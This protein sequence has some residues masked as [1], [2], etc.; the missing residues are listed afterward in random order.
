[1]L[2]YSSNYALFFELPKYYPRLQSYVDGDTLELLEWRQ[3]NWAEPPRRPL[4]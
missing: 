2:N 3:M 1:M 4:T